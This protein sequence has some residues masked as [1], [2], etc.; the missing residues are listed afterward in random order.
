MRENANMRIVVS[1]KPSGMTIITM[2]ADEVVDASKTMRISDDE[3]CLMAKACSDAIATE[4]ILQTE[5]AVR[6]FCVRHR[7]KFLHGSLANYPG[8]SGE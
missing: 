6:D 3:I 2:N 5:Q 4:I 7:A 1:A 8:V